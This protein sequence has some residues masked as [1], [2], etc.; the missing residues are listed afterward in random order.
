MSWS[1]ARFCRWICRSKLS[2]AGR[3]GSVVESR[4]PEKSPLCNFETG[5]RNAASDGDVVRRDRGFGFPCFNGSGQRQGPRPAARCPVTVR[6]VPAWASKPERCYR[7]ERDPASGTV[8][9]G[10]GARRSQLLRGGGPGIVVRQRPMMARRRRARMCQVG[11]KITTNAKFRWG[12]SAALSSPADEKKTRREGDQGQL[13]QLSWGFTSF[14]P[15]CLGLV[16]E[17]AALCQ[18]SCICI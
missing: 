10:L 13:Q 3:F 16:L 9:D 12:V 8:G 5:G 11:R 17:M 14:F 2:V 1:F 6:R 15:P 4:A 7:T 18:P